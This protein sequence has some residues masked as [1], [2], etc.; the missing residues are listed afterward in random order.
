M[1]LSTTETAGSRN[2]STATERR[3]YTIPEFAESLGVSPAFLRIESRRGRLRLT[4]FG[5][6]VRV[7]RED[8]EAYIARARGA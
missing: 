2:P 6:A 3:G 4:R 8:A 1:Q 5:R 7:M